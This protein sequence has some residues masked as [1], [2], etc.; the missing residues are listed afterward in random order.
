MNALRRPTYESV[1]DEICQLD[2]AGLTR[3]ELTHT[4]WA[5]YFFSIQFRENLQIARKLHPDDDKLKQLER[6][7]CNTSNL[8]PW[9]GVAEAGEKMNHDEFMRRTLALSEIDP[10]KRAELKNLGTSYLSKVR[11]V[12]EATRALSLASYEDGGLERLFRAFLTSPH[13]DTP[14]LQAFQHFLTEHIRFDSDPDQGHGAL[15]RHL[16]PD[17]R[18]LPLW[19]ALKDLLLKAVP[20]LRHSPSLVQA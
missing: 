12:D 18:I 17:D 7:E 20:A 16:T 1:I 14:L 15:S 8:S 9:P 6:E 3:D 19:T 10:T 2:W 4:A 13:W 5:Y 11:K